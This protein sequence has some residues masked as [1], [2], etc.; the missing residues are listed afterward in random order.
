MWFWH[1][2]GPYSQTVASYSIYWVSELTLLGSALLLWHV[3]LSNTAHA[4]AVLGSCLAM[5]AQMG[6]LGA[7]ITFARVPIYSPH[8]ATTAPWGLTA[9]SDQQ[10]AGLI[11]WIPA[12]IP[13]VIFGLMQV[14]T[15]L[16]PRGPE[17]VASG[18]S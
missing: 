10:L 16:G 11:M 3:L 15:R 2:P 14:G 8:F 5:I 9:L 1:A 12:A 4:G 6:L 13:Y 7:V 18:A 17:I